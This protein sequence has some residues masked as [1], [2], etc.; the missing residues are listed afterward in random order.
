MV[1]R[2]VDD[3][4]QLVDC[5]SFSFCYKR[6]QPALNAVLVNLA[7]S[8]SSLD[9]IHLNE[10]YIERSLPLRRV[11]ICAQPKSYSSV[12]FKYEIV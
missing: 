4:V 12:A 10:I 9:I 1:L 5:I 2:S 3:V 6:Y 11:D 8:G 7:Y